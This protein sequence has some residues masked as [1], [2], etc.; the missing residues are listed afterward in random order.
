[1]LKKKKR[2]CL[3]KGSFWRQ[4]VRLQWCKGS[5]SLLSGRFGYPY[6]RPGF[7][8][9]SGDSR[10]IRESWYVCVTTNHYPLL[11]VTN[12]NYS[13]LDVTTHHYPLLNVTSGHYS[14]LDVTA[15]H[16]PLLN[17]TS[18]HYPSLDVTMGLFI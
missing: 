10:I 3:D 9:Y 6:G 12:I 11:N 7:V 13:S 4:D 18:S 17:V 2:N 14:S 15:N 1:M 5:K 8:L 16:Q